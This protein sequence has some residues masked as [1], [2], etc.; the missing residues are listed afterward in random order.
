VSDDGPGFSDDALSTAFEPFLRPDGQSAKGAGLGLSIVQTLTERLGGTVSLGRSE[1]GGARIDLN[2]PNCR[3]ANAETGVGKADNTIRFDGLA[4]LL[5]E[6]NATNQLIA[7][8]FLEQLG[9]D[10]T[11]CGDGISG[12]ETARDIGFDAIFMDID[13]PGMNGT[14]VMRA[15]R[16]GEGPNQATPLIAFTAFA[17]RSEREEILKAGANTI[18]AKPVSARDDFAN[19]LKDALMQKGTALPSPKLE[20]TVVVLDP[21]RLN[22]LRETLGEEDFTELTSEFVSDLET[23]RKDLSCAGRNGQ[24]VRKATHIVIGVAGAIGAMKA[25]AAAEALNTCAH[26]DDMDGIE[27]QTASLDAAIGETMT[28]LG[29]LLEAS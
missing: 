23:L 20:N 6:D 21:K 8:R 29:L 9:C 11:V 16:R 24:A 18:L 1:E 14:D 25:Q 28:A 15:I 3:T 27:N 5:V 12:L 19:A 4:V 2:F 13:L 26:T 22:S 17:I 7:S 10:V